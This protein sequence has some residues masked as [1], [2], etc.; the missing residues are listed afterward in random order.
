MT[1]SNKYLSIISLILAAFVL[2]SGVSCTRQELPGGAVTISLSSCLP[3]TRGAAEIKDGSEIYFGTDDNPDLILLIFDNNGNLVARYPDGANSEK[4]DGATPTDFSIRLKKRTNGEQ[5]PEGTYAVY[6]VANTGEGLWT[7]SDGTNAVSIN[8]LKTNNS[9]T[10]TTLENLIFTGVPTDAGRLPLTAKGTVTVN[11]AGNG[12]AALSLSR[13]VAKVVVKLVNNFG[14]DLTLNPFSVT[15]T[16]LVSDKGYLF[17]HTPDFPTGVSYSDFSHSVPNTD[18]SE[19]VLPYNTNPDNAIYEI[20]S[21]VFP[22]TGSYKCSLSFSITKVGQA[23]LAPPKPFNFQDLSVHNN[24]GEDIT[25]VAR[26]QCLTITVSINKG[27][28]LSFNFDVSDWTEHTE[29]VTF[30]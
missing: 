26:N 10:K 21:F 6:A 23:T 7:M 30:D 27:S 15:L 11:T 16:N 4:M 9:L 28:M 2:L 24:R 18:E 13:P 8:I 14:N 29:N 1:M 22:G 3:E 20:P 5:I 17:S 19:V 25:S 12:N